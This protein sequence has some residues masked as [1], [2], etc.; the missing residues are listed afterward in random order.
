MARFDGLQYGK[1]QQEVLSHVYHMHWG[2]TGNPCFELILIEKARGKLPCL[3]HLDR[4]AI[5]KFEDDNDDDDKHNNTPLLRPSK[6]SGQF[7]RGHVCHH[8]TRGVQ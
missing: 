2:G 1:N 3:P 8:T 6:Q 5:L 4:H 7:H